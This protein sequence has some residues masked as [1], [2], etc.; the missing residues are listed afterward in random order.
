MQKILHLLDEEIN[1]V[2]KTDGGSVELIDVNGPLVTV[3]MRGNCTGCKSRQITL[4]QFIEKI[5]HEHVDSDII[6][7]EVNA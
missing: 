1:P 5:L 7:E 3:A 4:S 2:L 6:V